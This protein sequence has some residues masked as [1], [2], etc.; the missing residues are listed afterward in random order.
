MRETNMMMKTIGCSFAAFLQSVACAGPTAESIKITPADLAQTDLFGTSAAASEGMLIIGSRLH[1]DPSSNKGAAYLFETLSG[2]QLDKYITSDGQTGGNFG[3]AVAIDMLSSPP[4]VVIGKDQ[5]RENG[6]NAGAVYVFRVDTG[7]EVFRRI[8][9]GGVGGSRFG[10]AVDVDNNTCVVGAN[11]SSINGSGAGRA[12]LFSTVNGNLLHTLNPETPFN[13]SLFGNSVSID[14]DVVMVAARREAEFGTNSGVVYL[15]DRS[16]GNQLA[17]FF[18][19]DG[20]PGDQFG[21]SVSMDGGLAAISAIADGDNGSGSG[22]VYIYD[23]STPTTP[24][25]IQKILAPDGASGDEFGYSVAIRE[26]SGGFIVASGAWKAEPAGDDSGSSY[27]F[28]LDSQGMLLSSTI[29]IASDSSED[30]EFGTCVAIDTDGSVIVGA[31]EDDTVLSNGGSAYIYH[32][33]AG[34]VADFNGD[35]TTNFFDVSA[36]LSAFQATDPAAD[37]NGDGA[38][39]FFDISA[40]LSLFIEGCP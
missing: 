37:L 19:A 27:S 11:L 36:F 32:A 33:Q 17:R 31:A 34:C 14:G 9:P 5:D 4:V 7:A 24:V 35:G 20:S 6:V 1:D 30:A 22:S 26:V 16:T 13:N 2:T 28:E 23:I 8:E 39:N 25:Q 10:S 38:L 3:S 12:Y 40:F 15:F 21:Y 29:L 18:P